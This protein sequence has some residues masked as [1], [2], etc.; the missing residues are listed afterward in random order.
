MIGLKEKY[1]KQIVKELMGEF[2]Y[3]NK[4]EVPRVV[5]LV[6]SEGIKEGTTNPKAADIAAAEMM[7]FVGQ[8]VVIKKAKKSIANF[9]LKT[10][11][12]IGCMVTLRGERMYLFLNK[13]INIAMPKIRDFR[14]LS[15]KSFDGRGNY[16]FGLKEQLIFPE[17]DYDKV[18]KT[19][20]MNIVIVTTAKTDKEARA[21]LSKLG[22]PFRER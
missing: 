22:I 18:D 3:K 12:P 21:L 10:H 5:K 15:P 17:V 8:H 16:S 6:L 4:M 2:G 13:L 14:G 20:G 7:S 19:R 1:D 9:K 11:D